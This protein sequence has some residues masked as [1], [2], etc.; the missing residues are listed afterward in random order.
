MALTLSTQAKNLDALLSTA[1]SALGLAGETAQRSRVLAYV[2]LLQRWNAVHNLSAT[3]DPAD[4]VEQH[5]V[6]C[7]AIIPALRRHAANR[8]LAL[9]DA[10]TGAGLPA[11][12]VAIMLSDWTVTAV[13]SVGKKVAFLR[14]VTGE[15]GLSNLEP[16][17][18]RLEN[19]SPSEGRFDL[20]TSRAFGALSQLVESTKHLIEP[21]GVWVAMK[22]KPPDTE[23]RDLPSNCQLFHVEPLAVPGLNAQR[24]LVW[25]KPVT[26]S[27]ER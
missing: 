3:R 16:R 24:C 17:H 18:T 2:S 6:D 7:L 27:R 21:T 8:S 23:I 20:V 4:L 19:M 14:Q 1:F 9:L 22:G 15:L 26:G 25:I 11:V 12:V 5:V 10:G 13:D